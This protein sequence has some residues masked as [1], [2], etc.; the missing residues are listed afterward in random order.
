MSRLLQLRLRERH[1]PHRKP[2]L[3][4]YNSWRG[5]LLIYNPIMAGWGGRIRTNM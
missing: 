1:R 2:A 3:P 5:K 4:P